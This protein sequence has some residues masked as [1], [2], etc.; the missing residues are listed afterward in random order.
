[1]REKDWSIVGRVKN[2]VPPLAPGRIGV[3]SR[4]TFVDRFGKQR[5]G[6]A[7]MKGPHGWVLNMGGRHG[8]P[9]VPRP[10]SI[11]K[12]VNPRRKKNS[13]MKNAAM[14]ILYKGW[15]IYGPFESYEARQESTGVEF[16]GSSLSAIKKTIDEYN[17]S[18]PGKKPKFNPSPEWVQSGGVHIDIGTDNKGGKTRVNP[19]AALMRRTKG[20]KRNPVHKVGSATDP[21]EVWDAMILEYN[22]TKRSADK[23]IPVKQIEK[24]V[25]SLGPASPIRDVK[26]AIEIRARNFKGWT[27]SL[28]A[29]A[30]QVA[31]ARQRLNQA[32]DE[33]TQGYRK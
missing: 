30:V 5:T 31:V 12:V 17:T 24:I 11:V 29:Q 18:Y 1:M 25:D 19:K 10:D 6:T 2:P 4:V 15:K 26:E 28:I 16:T 27:E 22:V 8:T 20:T 3:G 13:R 32:L 23:L 14:F 33:V 9:A 21:R 7:V